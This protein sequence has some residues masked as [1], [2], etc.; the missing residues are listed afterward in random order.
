MVFWSD[1][2]FKEILELIK[3]RKKYDIHSESIVKILTANQERYVAIIDDKLMVC[4][5]KLQVA[6][7]PVFVHKNVLIQEIQPC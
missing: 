1:F 3:I 2:H 7:N 4:I 5:G 6:D